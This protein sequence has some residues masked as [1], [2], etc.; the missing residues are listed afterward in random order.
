MLEGV[1]ETISRLLFLGL[2]VFPTAL[3]HGLCIK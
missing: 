3:F 1:A 2:P